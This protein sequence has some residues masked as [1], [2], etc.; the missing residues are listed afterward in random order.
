M[1]YI[2]PLLLAGCTFNTTVPIGDSMSQ[3]QKQSMSNQQRQEQS[4]TNSQTA[5][6]AAD[7]QS[8]HASESKQGTNSMPVVIICNQLGSARSN[9]IT[10]QQPLSTSIKELQK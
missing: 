8:S 9:C 6:T 4:Q 2:L 3:Q 10:P 7:Q 5:S 1:K